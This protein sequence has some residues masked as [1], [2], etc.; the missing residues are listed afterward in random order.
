MGLI[1][2]PISDAQRQIFTAAAKVAARRS[3]C[4]DLPLFVLAERLRSVYL[5]NR[6]T[7]DR[8]QGIGGFFQHAFPVASVLDLA[9]DRIARDAVSVYDR[10]LIPACSHACI[11]CRGDA[12]FDGTHDFIRVSHVVG[13]DSRSLS[14][15][16]CRERCC[17][18]Y[19]ITYSSGRTSCVKSCRS[20][21]FPACRSSAAF[22]SSGSSFPRSFALLKMPLHAFSLK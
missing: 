21:V 3:K 13:G 15:P 10:Y 1:H 14:T 5:C 19:L 22:S 16:S 17:T 4:R 12:I 2:L 20:G 18:F 6:M 8:V 7:V 11:E 9:V